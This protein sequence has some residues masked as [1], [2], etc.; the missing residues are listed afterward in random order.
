MLF[1]NIELFKV[2]FSPT[3]HTAPPFSEALLLENVAL[4][5][6]VLLPIMY[7][8]PPEESSPVEF[9]K[10]SSNATF[11]MFTLLPVKKIPPPFAERDLS[12]SVT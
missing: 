12:V 10:Q 5:T 8:A 7:K 1:A 3:T 11:V 9:V 2:Q 6:W 4:T